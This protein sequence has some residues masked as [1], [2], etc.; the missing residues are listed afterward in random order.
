MS[1]FD[2]TNIKYVELPSKGLFR[3]L[4]FSVDDKT[5]LAKTLKEAYRDKRQYGLLLKREFEAVTKLHSSYLPEYYELVDDDVLGRCIIE[6]FVEGRSLTDYLAEAHSEE[7]QDIVA[8]QLMTALQTIHCRFMVHRNLKPSNILITK[9]GNNVKLLNL[10]PQFADEIQAPY[11]STRYLAPE[12]KDE[13][14]AVDTRADIYSLGLILRQMNLPEKF[15]L[16]IAKCCSLGRGDRYMYAEDVELALDARPS[17]NLGRYFKVGGVLLAVA[18][19]VGASVFAVKAAM[20]A[21][22]DAEPEEATSYVLPDSTNTGASASS[23]MQDTL[24]MISVSNVSATLVDSVKNVIAVRLE[25]IYRPY[26]NDSIDQHTRKL[27]R[28]QVRNSYYA[29]MRNLGKVSPAER[30]AIDQYFAKYRQNKDA[31]LKCK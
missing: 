23:T 18:V 29:I 12:Q 5:Y 2:L 15:A 11:T 7:E 13:T 17:I 24:K 27:I 21:N 16:V 3:Y 31:M 10:R 20:D 22:S 26:D 1:K 9:Q 6:E 19:I 8:R 28:R 25:S 14:V 4:R 30:D